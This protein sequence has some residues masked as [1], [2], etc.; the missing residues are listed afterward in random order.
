M[1]IPAENPR[2]PP[3]VLEVFSPFGG[4]RTARSRGLRRSLAVPLSRYAG[5][6]CGIR[7]K[8][9]SSARMQDRDYRRKWCCGAVLRGRAGRFHGRD[10]A[11]SGL[12][13]RWN[14]AES[15]KLTKKRT[16]VTLTRRKAVAG[17][18]A[19]A[20]GYGAY[21]SVPV[22][23]RPRIEFEPLDEPRGFR[24]IA[25]GKISTG[26]APFA[27]ISSSSAPDPLLERA[28][29]I[30]ND[31]I[32]GALFGASKTDSDVVRLASF[33][34]YYCPYCR[35]QTKRLSLIESRSGGH[36]RVVWHELPLLGDGSRLVAKAALAARRQGAYAAFQKRM[37]TASFQATPAYLAAVSN[38]LG[39]DYDRL[40]A[41]MSD[42]DID[43][44]LHVSAELARRFGF[45]GTPALVIGSTAVQGEIGERVTTELIAIERKE[46]RGICA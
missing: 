31:D 11:R 41:D 44:E 30:V 27:G 29:R 10:R 14:R 40:D 17:A 35:V 38:S 9:R 37:M 34:D 39:L 2:D 3:D 16:D 13:L 4:A 1:S 8:R 45:I 33:S 24:R 21:R 15:C 32:C 43:L 28:A 26:F 6:I 20:T 23:F 12:T 19:L 46:Q 25:G 42:P 5:D 36:V 7:S 18:V 22:V